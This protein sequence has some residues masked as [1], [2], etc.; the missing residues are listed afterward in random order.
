MIPG[1]SWTCRLRRIA[2]AAVASCSLASAAALAV[3]AGPAGAKTAGYVTVQA[4]CLDWSLGGAPAAASLGSADPNVVSQLSVLRAPAVA[5]DRV[6]ASALFAEVLGSAGA[7]TYDPSG[8]RVIERRGQVRVYA[9]PASVG[10][11]FVPA[12]C[13]VVEGDPPISTLLQVQDA[14]V[15]E[16][17]GVCLV[18]TQQSQGQTRYKEPN[19]EIATSAACADLSNLDSY[20]G[21]L[22]VVPDLHN[23]SVFLVPDGVSRIQLGY[24]S[25]RTV[26]ER[27]ARNLAILPG[28]VHLST[29]ST[30]PSIVGSYTGFLPASVTEGA[31]G[32]YTLPS[33][34]V[35]LI[36]ETA[37]GELK[38]IDTAVTVG[39]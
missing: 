6:P 32:M 16:G 31:R 26:N 36:S 35:Q 1:R 2:T 30:M 33:G 28:H 12:E 19:G 18:R 25:G 15:G 24:A 10:S 4:Q 39:T 38:V 37:Y 11:F 9:V 23:H 34:L 14:T 3:S 29:R 27:V 5:I 17:P 20:P 21:I 8:I 13:D 22:D 7:T